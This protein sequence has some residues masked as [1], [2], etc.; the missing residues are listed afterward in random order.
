MRK[1]RQ[2]SN[3]LTSFTNRVHPSSEIDYFFYIPLGSEIDYFFYVD[4]SSEIHYFST[5]TSSEISYFNQSINQSIDPKQ[6]KNVFFGRWVL[7]FA[8]NFGIEIVYFATG[9]YSSEIVYFATQEYV[10][11]IVYFATRVYRTCAD[12][13]DGSSTPV[14]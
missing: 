10:K 1:F 2:T 6:K 4:P 9:T 14:R 13:R 5:K 11:E 12:N 3:V 7:C 8:T